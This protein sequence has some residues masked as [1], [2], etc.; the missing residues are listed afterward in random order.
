MSASRNLL[1][2]APRAMLVDALRGVTPTTPTLCEGW[3]ARH[4]AA[5]VV[6]RERAPWRIAA[7]SA[8]HGDAALE[9]GDRVTTLAE[10]EALVGD[11]EA[12]PGPWSPMGWSPRMNAAEFVIHA[13]DA[14][15]GVSL[16]QEPTR[17]VPEIEDYLWSQLPFMA[18]LALP[19]PA[20]RGEVG[21]VFV[22]PGG[23]RAVIARGERSAVVTGTVAEL[24]LL[25]FGRGRASLARVWGP[26]AA[27]ESFV[28]ATGMP[29]A[30][31]A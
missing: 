18:K 22:V 23:P 9:A 28:A 10:Y 21:V 27:A 3:Q 31:L 26:R 2:S 14:Q 7:R 17:L 24:A 11:V 25:V 29:T 5:H 4:L 19:R 30:S 8:R 13:L 6:L 15:R 1:Y 20:A 12:G 16:P